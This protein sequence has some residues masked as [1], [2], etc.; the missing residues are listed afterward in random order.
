[1]CQSIRTG[2]GSGG[3]RWICELQYRTLANYKD[4]EFL[5]PRIGDKLIFSLLVSLQRGMHTA[6]KVG[7]ILPSKLGTCCRQFGDVLLTKLSALSI[8]RLS[9]LDWDK[10]AAERAVC[11]ASVPL[12]GLNG[13]AS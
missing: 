3:L 12:C 4:P 7:G 8:V 10:R 11:T 1:M 13:M 2:I 6:V 9:Y 5:G